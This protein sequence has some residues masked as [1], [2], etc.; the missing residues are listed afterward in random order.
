VE[1][2]WPVVSRGVLGVVYLAGF[3]ALVYCAKC[4]PEGY[5]DA[6][7]F[8]LGNK[9]TAPLPRE[10]NGDPAEVESFPRSGHPA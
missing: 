3:I 10:A 1:N 5:E 6:D 9:P 4:A 2:I 7:G 8:R